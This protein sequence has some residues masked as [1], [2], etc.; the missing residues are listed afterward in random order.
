[1]KLYYR[2]LTYEYNLEEAAKKAT[3]PFTPVRHQ[4]SCTIATKAFSCF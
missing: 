3:R 1:M 4:G 2:G